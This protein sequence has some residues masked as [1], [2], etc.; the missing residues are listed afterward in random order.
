MEELIVKFDGKEYKVNVEES[1]KGKIRVFFNGNVYEVETK[2]DAEQIIEEEIEKKSIKK[3]G[4]SIV[5]APLPGT[6]ASVDVKKNDNVNS[7]NVLLKLVAMKMENEITAIK[8][9]RIKEI[10]V[11]KNDNVKKGDI[12][13]VIE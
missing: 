12:L 9:G 13:V 4:K 10:K 11:K 8:S 7:G 5:R 2:A 3:E 1:D 6:V